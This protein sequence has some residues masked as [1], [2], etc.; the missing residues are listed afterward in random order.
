MAKDLTGTRTATLPT[1]V[2]TGTSVGVGAVASFLMPAVRTDEL[3]PWWM[4]RQNDPASPDVVLGDGATRNST[5]RSWAL[6]GTVGSADHGVI[7]PRGM[8]TPRAGGFS[9]DWWVGADDRWHL[10]S[11][12]GAVRQRLVDDS[13]VV[14]TTMRVPGGE[15]VHRAWAVAAGE[16]VPVG[17]AVV[18]ELRNASAVPVA[19]ALAVRPFDPIGRST[20]SH[21]DL[22][23]SVVMIDGVPAV[24]LSKLPSRIAVGSAALGDSLTIVESGAAVADWPAGGVRCD[25]G[26]ASAALLFPLPHTASIRLLVPLADPGGKRRRRIAPEPALR[27]TPAAAADAERVVAGWEVQTRRSPRIELLERRAPEALRA[28]RRFALLHAAGDDAASWSEGLVGV[29]DACSLIVALDQQGLHAEAARLIMGLVD[30]IDVD[31]RF[32]QEHH[33]IDA[34]AAWLHAV[35]R[36]VAL[37]GDAVLA[38]SVAAEVAKIAHRLHRD[39][40]GSGA[41]RRAD[42]AAGPTW[43]SGTSSIRIHDLIWAQSGL[44]SGEFVLRV[45]EQDAAAEDVARFAGELFGSLADVLD[46]VDGDLEIATAAIVA[47]VESDSTLMDGDS[48]RAG[49]LL[50]LAGSGSIAGAIWH[51]VGGAGMSPRLTAALGMARAQLGDPEA[52][53]AVRWMLDVG[54]PTWSWPTFVHPRT[55]DGCGGDGHSP[56]STSSFL[57][58]VRHLTAI[59]DAGSINILPAVPRDW[60][61]QP[62]EVHDLPTRHGL[63]SFAVRWHGERPAVLW[64]L[65]PHADAS[66]LSGSSATPVRLR[67]GGLDPGWSTTEA[68][69]ETLLAAPMIDAD[70]DAETSADQPDVAAV[71]VS[72]P[73]PRKPTPEG[74]S[75]S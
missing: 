42:R 63:L 30:R 68:R 50:E 9:L 38:R 34:G 29:F 24:H 7:D 62:I 43:T 51:R 12:S 52:V 66:D 56:V 48:S 75:F 16:G 58:L 6:L 20:V 57:R 45:A 23:D 37:A 70:A 2:L 60:L 4:H 19:L 26:R 3:L 59:D 1:G 39:L 31:G 53:L 64:E 71:V 44:V 36:H 65:A 27:A 73:E 54:E 55:G 8:V 47:L 25:A 46:H 41:R 15:V 72:D 74:G 69:G 33:R 67:F 13:P 21:I 5:H 18:I 35:A 22:I 10:P 61:G 11:R 32:E 40:L 28:A 17:G 14:E 49:E